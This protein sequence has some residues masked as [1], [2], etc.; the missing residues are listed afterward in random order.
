MALRCL[1]QGSSGL[2][3]APLLEFDHDIGVFAGSRMHAGEHYVGTLAGQRQSVLHEHLDQM[4][5]ARM[6][7]LGE[8]SRFSTDSRSAVTDVPQGST[9]IPVRVGA[10]PLRPEPYECGR[11]RKP[12]GPHRLVAQ[13][14]A[15]A[16][17][18]GNRS[19]TPAWCSSCGTLAAGSSG[20][21]RSPAR[22]THPAGRRTVRTG[23]QKILPSPHSQERPA[24]ASSLSLLGLFRPRISGRKNAP[25]GGKH[26]E[27]REKN[28]HPPW[29]VRPHSS[30]RMSLCSSTGPASS[31]GRP[32]IPYLTW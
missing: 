7:S 11:M 3:A 2:T 10:Y 17:S 9:R 8:A 28:S 32:G 31:K 16:S 6:A 29:L 5:S 26:A 30:R 1:Y 25:R 18:L 14:V 24:I 20:T 22:Q 4:A 21:P 13:R 12:V 23:S 27:V 19:S 15:G